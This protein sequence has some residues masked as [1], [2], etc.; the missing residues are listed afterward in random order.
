M[1]IRRLLFAAS[2]F[3]VAPI[4]GAG[5][6]PFY[7]QP[8]P[9]YQE[10]ATPPSWSYNPYTS[11]QAPCPQGIPGDLQRCSQKMPPTYGQPNYWPQR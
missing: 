3:A 10:P 7:Y 11:G 1:T 4:A 8:A 9:L 5:A 2:I 6:Q